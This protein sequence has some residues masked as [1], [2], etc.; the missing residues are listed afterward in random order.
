MLA[1]LTDEILAIDS[2]MNTQHACCDDMLIL[3]QKMH[4]RFQRSD[5]TRLTRPDRRSQRRFHVDSG[6]RL[7]CSPGTVSTPQV[8]Q[9]S[10]LFERY[11]PA[12][13]HANA[14][15]L[16]AFDDRGEVLLNG[17]GRAPTLVEASSPAA[18]TMDERRYGLGMRTVLIIAL[19]LST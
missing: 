6:A 15:R 4:N 19:P 1:T 10:D 11:F 9:D 17:L 18:H 7:V 3:V 14:A 13:Q 12:E 16:A 2:Q 5:R 8:L